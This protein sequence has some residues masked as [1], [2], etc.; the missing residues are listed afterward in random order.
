MTIAE[1][2]FV[3]LGW[4]IFPVV[5]A[6]VSVQDRLRRRLLLRG[7]RRGVARDAVLRRCARFGARVEDLGPQRLRLWSTARV[8]IV[9]ITGVFADVAFDV[10][11]GVL[12]VD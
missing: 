4:G 8:G 3:I 2:A 12:Y 6:F 9:S 10:S 5:F 1:L 7:I 11:G